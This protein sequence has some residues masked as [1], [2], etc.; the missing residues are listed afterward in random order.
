M[1][2]GSGRARRTRL[3]PKRHGSSS[4]NHEAVLCFRGLCCAPLEF[5]GD[6]IHPSSLLCRRIYRIDWSQ[7]VRSSLNGLQSAINFVR[8]DTQ[9]W[10]EYNPRSRNPFHLS[11]LSRWTWCEIYCSREKS[12]ACAPFVVVFSLKEQKN[13]QPTTQNR[14]ARTAGSGAPDESGATSGPSSGGFFAFLLKDKG[15]NTRYLLQNMLG[16]VLKS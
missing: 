11:P 9:K 4:S 1:R 3:F 12:C 5:S 15:T 7:Q 10:K 2:E 13:S 6:P 16:L 8:L 14:S